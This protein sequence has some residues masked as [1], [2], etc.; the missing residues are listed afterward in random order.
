[1]WLPFRIDATVLR[2]GAVGALVSAIDIAALW[3]LHAEAGL[4]LAAATTL[5]FCCAF[6]VNLTLNRIFTFRVSGPMGR[7]GARLLVLCGLNYVTTLAIVVG[8]S[9]IWGA[10]LASK[11]IATVFNA[12]FN[13]FAYRRWVFAHV[14]DALVPAPSTPPGEPSADIPKVGL[15]AQHTQA[16]LRG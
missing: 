1:M 6:V 9:H 3:V 11:T 5:A 7:Q 2:F 12:A 4:P 8:L 14:A 15:S 13:F 16:S 10:Y